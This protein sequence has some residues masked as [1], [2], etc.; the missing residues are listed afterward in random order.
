MSEFDKRARDWDNDPMKVER[1]R[2]VADGIRRRV[3][4]GPEIAALEYGCGTGLLSFNLRG[5]LGPITLADTSSGMLDVLRAKI[6]AED[7]HEM[8]PQRLDLLR[9][10]V[11]NRRFHLVYTMMT[12][13]HIPDTAAIL[14]R[15]R[16]VLDE[17]GYLCI[18]DLDREDGSFHGAGFD[19]HRGFDRPALHALARR[20]GFRG[21]TF[22]TVY[23]IRKLVGTQVREFPVFLMTA[24]RMA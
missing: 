22:D 4:L 12:L 2:A 19:G 16:E 7:A 9:E 18:A 10:S 15:F 23:R 21:I 11:G 3:A 24:R 1:A 6:A 14:T 17:G 8:T 5:E 13:H 20:C